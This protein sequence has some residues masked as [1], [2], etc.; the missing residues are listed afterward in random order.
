[1]IFLQDVS[2]G[3]Q[4]VPV[5]QNIDL[6][7]DK[8]EF[9]GIIGLSGAGK[10]TL[11]KSMVGKTK[12]LSGE[13]RVCNLPVHK[14]SKKGMKEL[15][16]RVGFIFQGYNLVN[17]LNVLHNVMSGMLKDISLM[18]SVIKFYNAAEFDHAYECMKLVGIEQLALKRSD[19]LSGGERQRTAIARA[20]VQNPELILADEP[21]A[22][23]DPKSAVTVMDILQNINRSF[24]VTVIANL[25]HLDLARRYCSR[26]LGISE[27]GIIFDG[28]PAELCSQHV[29]LVYRRR[30][31]AA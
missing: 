20:L 28:S 15:R 2:I 19:E 3:Y 14:S 11:L 29:E 13:Y 23:L 31:L 21:V 12:I 27:G 7:V 26:I 18:R 6:Q 4:H 5:L 8:G 10:S 25:H 9:I 17:R 24:G 30:M 1:M 16:S 22:A